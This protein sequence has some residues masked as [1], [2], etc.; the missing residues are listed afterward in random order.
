MSQSPTPP[1]KEFR[2]RG[3]KAA[4]WRKDVQKDGH[5]FVRHSVRIQKSYRDEAGNWKTTEYFYPEDLPRLALVAEKAFEF[6][7]LNGS[8]EAPDTTGIPL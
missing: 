6:I 3:I 5:T 2:S 4:I 8:E 1:I 7:S